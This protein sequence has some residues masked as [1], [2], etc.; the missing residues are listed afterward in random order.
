[1]SYLG[2]QLGQGQAERWVCTA[3]AGQTSITV[4]DDGRSIAYTPQQVDVY[5]N[6]SKQVNGSD[7]TVSSGTAIVFASG[8]TAGDVVD[9]V[10]LSTFN[11]ADTV[12]RS[13]GGTFLGAVNFPSGG[14][15]VGSGQLQVDSGGRVLAPSQP[16]FAGY[17]VTTNHPSPGAVLPVNTLYNSINVGGHWNTSTYQFTCPVAGYYHMHGS[18]MTDS[19]TAPSSAVGITTVIPQKNG[20]NIGPLWYLD[21]NDIKYQVR[22]SGDCIVQAAAG[23]TL[24]FY[25]SSGKIHKDAYNEFFI[26]LLG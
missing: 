3:T 21:L 23:D 19:Y 26:R 4:G 20:S 13:L 18:F 17:I 11:A 2:Q 6:G 14:L 5:L 10:A 25:L 7:V 24:R 16:L 15:N 12:S 9:V 22:F 8:L 1:M